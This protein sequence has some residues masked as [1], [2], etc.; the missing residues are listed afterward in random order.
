MQTF[1]D[2]TGQDWIVEITIG[3]IKR[4]LALAKIDLREP[5]V[6]YGEHKI[7]LSAAIELDTLLMADVLYAVCYPQAQDRGINQEAFYDLLGSDTMQ[8]AHQAL[9]REWADF[10]RRSG[11]SQMATVLEK[12]MAFLDRVVETTRQK[13]QESK[14]EETLDKILSSE[15]GNIGTQLTDSL[16]SA[17]STPTTSASGD[18]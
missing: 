10:F 8:A 17:V 2:R 15:I 12:Q 11:N 5:A 3:A 14:A 16:A 7:A 6:P 1:K 4:V 9:F 13:W 18:S